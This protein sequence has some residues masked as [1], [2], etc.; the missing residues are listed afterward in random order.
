VIEREL[1]ITPRSADLVFLGGGFDCMTSAFGGRVL[2]DTSVKKPKQLPRSIRMDLRYVSN[3]TEMRNALSVQANASFS[4]L[5]AEADLRASFAHSVNFNS[6]HVYI[7]GSVRIEDAA[8]GLTDLRFTEAAV[9]TLT[10][11]DL[12]A[13]H[14]QYGDMFVKNVVTGSELQVVFELETTS[15]SEQAAIVAELSA[16]G[17]GWG[18]GAEGSI[19][20]GS[21]AQNVRKHIYATMLGV[22]GAARLPTDEA[23]V[24]YAMAEFPRWAQGFGEPLQVVLQSYLGVSLPKSAR[25]PLSRLSSLRI[26]KQL[27]VLLERT[28]MLGND[29]RFIQAFPGQFE[30]VSRDWIATSQNEL[31]A[32]A[33]RV[34]ARA[35]PLFEPPGANLDT[36]GIGAESSTIGQHIEKIRAGLPARRAVARRL[37]VTVADSTAS[38]TPQ[39]RVALDAGYKATGGGGWIQHPRDDY[40]HGL[41]STWPVDA[42]GRQGW[43]IDSWFLF[44]NYPSP[45]GTRQISTAHACVLGLYDQSDDWEVRLFPAGFSRSLAG[46]TFTQLDVEAAVPA[47]FRLIGG[48]ARITGPKGRFNGGLVGSWPYSDSSWKARAMVSTTSSEPVTLECCAI[49]LRSRRDATFLVQVVKATGAEGQSSWAQARFDSP[50]VQLLGGGAVITGAATEMPPLLMSSVKDDA[51]GA[52]NAHA[53][54]LL[55]HNKVAVTAYAM[56]LKFS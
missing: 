36:A 49:G 10:S 35:E 52:W 20:W 34:R 44:E 14:D 45:R 53:Y 8:Q 30:T 18:V 6:Q 28:Q 19:E 29:L 51:L 40:Q 22:G 1:I 12:G 9:D 2:E 4:F 54:S 24:I 42:H 33:E 50:A 48:G 37:F 26:A 38:S 21:T 31:T 15:S 13:F 25:Q 41:R 27:G 3:L 46:G 7:V 17:A 55:G 43:D 32:L 39:L 47:E 11:G 56:G 23:G 5:G 16:K